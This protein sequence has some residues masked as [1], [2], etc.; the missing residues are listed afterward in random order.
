M[1][2]SIRREQN[3]FT[4]VEL[5]I[6]IVVIAILAAISLVTYN[7]ITVRA[8]DTTRA[9]D[10]Q[11]I[12]RE[13][14]LYNVTHNGVPSPPTY[15]GGNAG[16]WNLSSSSAWLSFLVSEYGKVPA[17]P[18][19]TGVGNPGPASSNSNYELTYFYYCYPAASPYVIVGYFSEQTQQKVFKTLDVLACL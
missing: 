16:G 6:V 18:V 14:L 7:G 3:G 17:D 8:R 2:T 9:Q 12:S 5:L 11:T 19:N 4:L 13:L 15:G 1:S 10:L